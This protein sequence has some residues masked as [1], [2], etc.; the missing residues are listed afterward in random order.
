MPYDP[1]LPQLPFT[2]R[3]R[4]GR[5]RVGRGRV[6]GRVGGRAGAVPP[7]VQDIQQAFFK[8]V[9]YRLSSHNPLFLYTPQ[10]L[11]VSLQLG[12]TLGTTG[13][14]RG[15]GRGAGVAGA[16]GRLGAGQRPSL[17]DFFCSVSPRHW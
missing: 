5:G 9:L 3:G 17:Q 14:G 10:L 7:A 12:D 11:I 13:C 4:V 15:R 16:D 2:R 1:H 8:Y 6:G